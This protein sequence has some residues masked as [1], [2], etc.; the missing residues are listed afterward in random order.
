MAS[1]FDDPDFFSNNN[2]ELCKKVRQNHEVNL[3]KE[4]IIEGEL[5]LRPNP[6][7]ITTKYFKIMDNKLIYFSVKKLSLKKFD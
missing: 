3:D 2:Y 6:N 1:F 7:L 4:V 5:S